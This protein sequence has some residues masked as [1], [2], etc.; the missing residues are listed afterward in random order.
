MEP[1]LSGVGGIHFGPLAET[2]VMRDVV[3][4]IL[5]HDPTSASSCRATSAICSCRCC[6]ITPRAIGRPSANLCLDRAEV[7]AGGPERAVAP[8]EY[9]QSQRGIDAAYTPIRASC[10]SMDDDVFYE[11]PCID[12]AYR[13]YE[14]RDLLAL[15]REDGR[16]STPMRALFRQNRMVSSIGG[17]FDHKSCWEVLTDDELAAR[18]LQRRGAALFRRHV[19]WTRHGLRAR[20]PR[21]PRRPRATCR[22]SP[23]ST[24]RSSCSSRTAATAARACTSARS[25]PQAEWERCSDE[26]LANADDPQRVWVVQ[27]AATLPVHRLPGVRRDGRV[28]DEPFYAVMGFAPTDHGLGMLCRVS[29]KQVVNVAQRGGLAPLLVGHRPAD[30]RA[31]LRAPV[32]AEQARE[33]LAARRS[34]NCATSTPRF[35][36]LELGRGDV[37]A[38]RRAP[39]AAAS[40][41]ASLEGLRHELLASDP[42]GDLIEAVAA[43]GKQSAARRASCARL[44]DPAARALA[45]PL[46]PRRGIR[47]GALALPRGVGGRARRRRLRA[48]RD[49]V[50]AAARR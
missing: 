19:L 48:V 25:T 21:L 14:M 39:T 32:R 7:R 28:H 3:P 41:S 2:L 29:Q 13:D 11:D 40:S 44:R 26:A 47:R 4:T 10:G 42:L 16:R 46:E 30:L 49:A 31:R 35:G 34:Q 23:A 22:S 5:A 6:S 9:Y 50:R 15:E 12:V 24:A 18:L 17:D 37:S 38:G 8:R 27:S 20:R 43:R 33:E 45:L 1:N 36:L